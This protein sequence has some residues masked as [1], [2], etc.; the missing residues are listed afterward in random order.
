MYYVALTYVTN[1][2][3]MKHIV[4]IKF[5]ATKL[6]TKW[7]GSDLTWT[8]Q[9]RTSQTCRISLRTKS[10]Q[11]HL[12]RVSANN[13]TT[14]KLVEKQ[15]SH[16]RRHL[17][18][19]VYWSWGRLHGRQDVQ[20]NQQSAQIRWTLHCHHFVAATHLGT[21]VKV[22]WIF[23]YKRLYIQ[24]VSKMSVFFEVFMLKIAF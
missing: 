23:L 8:L 14:Y 10:T 2:I 21:R 4:N 12:T 7:K 1:W 11:W 3:R 22:W 19:H 20:W 15:F 16:F 18:C 5:S 17:G 9:S 13:L 24:N 6:S